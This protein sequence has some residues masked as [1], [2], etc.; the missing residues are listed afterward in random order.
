[1]TKASSS[2]S[3]KNL[4]FFFYLF[5]ISK[6]V[7]SYLLA[8]FCTFFLERLSRLY[9]LQYVYQFLLLFQERHHIFSFWIFCWSAFLIRLYEFILHFFYFWSW[10]GQQNTCLNFL[11]FCPAAKT[12]HCRSYLILNPFLILFLICLQV[13][14]SS[15]TTLNSKNI[16]NCVFILCHMHVYSESTL[17][18]CLNV[19]E[20][21]AS[22]KQNI[23]NL[24]DC[25]RICTHRLLVH[26]WTPNHFTKLA[27][28]VEHSSTN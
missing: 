13:P 20:L 12:C 11:I 2:V 3:G 1:M 18:N 28:M 16:V 26:K 21:L 10:L 8:F 4:S 24:S 7:H 6:V 22:N 25:D 17:C 5:V 19:K 15:M 14:F 9:I 23:D 27:K